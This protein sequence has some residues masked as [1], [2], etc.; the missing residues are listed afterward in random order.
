MFLNSPP[1]GSSRAVAAEL[2]DEVDVRKTV[3]VHVRDGDPG[4]VVVVVRLVVLPGV[5]R[6][7]MDER[8]SASPRGRKN[9]NRERPSSPARPPWRPCSRRPATPVV[10]REEDG[11]RILAAKPS[12]PRALRRGGRRRRQSSSPFLPGRT[13]S[14]IP[15]TPALTQSQRASPQSRCRALR[16]DRGLDLPLDAVVARPLARRHEEPRE[17]EDD[18]DDSEASHQVAP[19]STSAWLDRSAPP[20][21]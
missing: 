7:V 5:L 21:G 20:N 17:A 8:D 15:I 18:Q 6:D 2:A 1:P 13:T 19:F 16:G 3:A 4:P 12:H 10:G 11:L 9:G 14:T